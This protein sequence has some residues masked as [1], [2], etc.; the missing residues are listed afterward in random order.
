MAT[1]SRKDRILRWLDPRPYARTWRRGRAL[2]QR[3]ITT[4]VRADLEVERQLVG[5]RES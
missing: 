1:A 4:T 2:R 3:R 5:T